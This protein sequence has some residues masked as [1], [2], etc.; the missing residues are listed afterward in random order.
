MESRGRILMA[1]DE[2]TF[3]RA[4][5]ALFQRAGYDCDCASDGPGVI[6]AA[7]RN[8]YDVV[9]TDINMTGNKDLELVREIR[10]RFTDLPVILVTGYPSLGT[11]IEALRLSAVDYLL[12]PVDFSELLGRVQEAIERARVTRSVAQHLRALGG[13]IERLQSLHPRATRGTGES[14]GVEQPA[15]SADQPAGT[16]ALRGAASPTVADKIEER[17]SRREREILR[18]VS[19]GQ[20]VASIA[21]LLAI[22][23]HTVRNHLKAIFRKVGVH[24]QVELLGHLHAQA[25]ADG[26]EGP[27]ATK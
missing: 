8:A 1:D 21:R 25:T 12:K 14:A 6:A 26:H 3:L 13:E 16:A 27:G 17:L 10:E 15:N 24:S 2:D 9:V 11:A 5:A 20:R 23:P 22:S 18:A 7:Q 19:S 4:T